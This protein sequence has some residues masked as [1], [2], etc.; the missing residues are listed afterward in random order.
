[1]K[2]GARMLR[3][4]PGLTFIG[5]LA[6][7]FA[8]WTGAV[9]FQILTLVVSFDEI[10]IFGSIQFFVLLLLVLVCG[11]AALLIFARA[12]TREGELVVRSAQGAGAPHR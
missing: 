12:A 3:K 7:A 11:N 4:Y 9:I 2:L 10:T 6:M 1:M 8:I 5:G